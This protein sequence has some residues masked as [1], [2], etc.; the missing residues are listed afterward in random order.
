MRIQKT[1]CQRAFGANL[2]GTPELCRLGA[3]DILDYLAPHVAP[4]KLEN[5]GPLGVIL[6]SSPQGSN[7]SVDLLEY[8]TRACVTLPVRTDL[9]PLELLQ[10]IKKAIAGCMEKLSNK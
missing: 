10:E 3:G 8:K 9:K 5:R 6:S 1:N 4:L 2:E 7:L